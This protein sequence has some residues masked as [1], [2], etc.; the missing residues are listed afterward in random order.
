MVIHDTGI[1]DSLA[2][3]GLVH[4][5]R[6]E[7]E[8]RALHSPDRR[9]AWHDRRGNLSFSSC[10]SYIKRSISEESDVSQPFLELQQK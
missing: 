4:L 3:E 1:L 5:A 10:V 6:F 8:L 7:G 2:W 9:Q